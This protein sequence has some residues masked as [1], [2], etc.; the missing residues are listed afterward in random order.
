MEMPLKR[1]SSKAV[2]SEN[3]RELRSSGRPEKQAVAIAM[4]EARRSSGKRES[5]M[6]K[7][8]ERKERKEDKK[9]EKKRPVPAAEAANMRASGARARDVA[10]TMSRFQ[11]SSRDDLTS[12][13][14]RGAAS[15]LGHGT[16]STKK[17]RR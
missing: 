13:R 2:I 6:P 16:G 9:Q 1:G 8:A 10:E 7:H 3:I 17:A 15:Q 11:G 5:E 12:D 4:S 14:E